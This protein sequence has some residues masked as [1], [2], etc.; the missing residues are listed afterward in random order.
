MRLSFS[1]IDGWRDGI[2]WPV[3]DSDTVR[4]D[5]VSPIACLLG[6]DGGCGMD[7]LIEWTDEAWEATSSI[8]KGAENSFV[9][10]CEDFGATIGP[11]TTRVYSLYVDSCSE[12]MET[13][14]FF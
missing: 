6:D 13:G 14:S 5:G 7:H 3:C 10:D 2:L 12:T 8:M 9:W 11:R 4:S 1:W